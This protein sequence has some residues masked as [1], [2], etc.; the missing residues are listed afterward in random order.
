MITRRT[1]LASAAAA[2]VMSA[3]PARAATSTAKN[4]LLVHGAFADGS[5]WA[6]VIPYLQAAGLRVIAVQ[7]AMTTLPGDVATTQRALAQMD[8][9]TVLVGHSYGGVVISQAGIDPKVSA[10]VYVA[11]LAPEVGEDFGSVAAKFPPA[12]GGASF[13]SVG[14]YLQLDPVGFTKDFMGDIPPA[15]ARMFAAVQGSVAASLL[16]EKT[17]ETAWKSKPTYYAISTKDRLVVPVMQRFLA[18]R[19]KAKTIEL[20]ASHASPVSKPREIA[21]LILQAAR[22]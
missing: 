2:G 20:A 14:G 4:V 1:V 21:D 11:A 8:G 7:N 17:S 19:M 12:P 3:V 9:P 10:L 5:S 18:A 13:R 15:Q 22:G 6:R 16:G